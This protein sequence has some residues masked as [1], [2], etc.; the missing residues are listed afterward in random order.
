MLFL[1]FPFWVEH[2]VRNAHSWLHLSPHAGYAECMCFIFHYTSSGVSSPILCSY[3][4]I[5]QT[6]DFFALS[7]ILSVY[8]TSLHL[9]CYITYFVGVY[10]II[11]PPPTPPPRLQETHV[12]QRLVIWFLTYL[13]DSFSDGCGSWVPT[14]NL[15]RV[16]HPHINSTCWSHLPRLHMKLHEH[17][18]ETQLNK[19]SR[20][21]CNCPQNVFQNSTSFFVA[22]VVKLL[23]KCS[24]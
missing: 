12:E 19:F 3:E 24:C 14:S 18:Q 23:L 15:P 2:V 6:D 9:L 1:Q 4:D 5:T 17:L 13:R 21:M 20:K 7:P 22:M 11:P 8:P 16:S 10:I